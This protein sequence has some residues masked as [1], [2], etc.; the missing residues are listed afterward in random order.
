DISRLYASDLGHDHRMQRDDPRV[1]EILGD[2]QRDS[3]TFT[4]TD[5]ARGDVVAFRKFHFDSLDSENF[6]TIAVEARYRDIVAATTGVSQRGFLFS[7]GIA[8]IALVFGVFML[9]LLLRP[10]NNVADGVVRYREGEKDIPLPT[11][12]PD[13]IGVLAKEFAAMMKQK[14]EE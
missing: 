10:L 3:A 4:P 14:N 8:L 6:L 7:A 9:R 12:S 13:E 2:P 11:D 1:L 5:T